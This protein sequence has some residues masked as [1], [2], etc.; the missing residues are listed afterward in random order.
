[1]V[2]GSQGR[3]EIFRVLGDQRRRF[4]GGRFADE[5]FCRLFPTD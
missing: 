4:R 5:G 3:F 1:L 2:L